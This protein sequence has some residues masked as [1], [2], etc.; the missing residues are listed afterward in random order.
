MADHVPDGG[1][2]ADHLRRRGSPLLGRPA[3]PRRARRGHRG[4][5]RS[6]RHRPQPASGAGPGRPRMSTATF[7]AP[8]APRWPALLPAVLIL[9]P[10]ALRLA[11]VGVPNAAIIFTLL[12][13]LMLTG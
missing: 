9:A 10:F 11:G 8:D 13:G 12:V 3:D 6:G 5:G 2:H 1:R 7:G 4:R